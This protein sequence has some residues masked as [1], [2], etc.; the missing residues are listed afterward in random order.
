MIRA[1]LALARARLS[2]EMTRVADPI[3]TTSGARLS[4]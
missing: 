3:G 1:W 2:I 4:T